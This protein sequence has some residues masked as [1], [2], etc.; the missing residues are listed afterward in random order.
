MKRALLSGVLATGLVSLLLA[1]PVTSAT[2]VVYKNITCP[3]SGFLVVPAGAAIELSDVVISSDGATDVQLFFN[4]PK[5]VFLNVFLDANESFSANFEGRVQGEGDQGL[6]LTCG[7]VA[8][9]SIT[10]TGGRTG[11]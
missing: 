2:G 3:K 5:F 4:P 1:A 6:K 8:T 11:L 7:G 9:V 10:V